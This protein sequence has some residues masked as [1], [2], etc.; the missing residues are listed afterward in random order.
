M[1][2][3]GIA[4]KLGNRYEAKIL[5]LKL[6]DVLTGKADWLRFE[7]IL[8]D[9]EGFE[10]SLGIGEKTEWYQTKTNS[11]HGNWTTSALKAAGVLDAFTKRL[12]E[13]QASTCHFVSQ[14][15]SQELQIFS[16]KTRIANDFEEFLASLSENKTLEFTNVAG[17][18]ETTTENCFSRLK[19]S[20]FE[21]ISDRL[22]ENNASTL[23]KLLFS[24]WNDNIFA[25]LRDYLE[26]NINKIITTD[27][28]RDFLAQKNVGFKDWTLDPT[29]QKKISDQT[30]RYLSTYIPFGAGGIEIKRNEVQ[31]LSDEI[32]KERG[33]R[34][35]LLTGSAG[36]GKSGVIRALIQDLQDQSI[37]HLAY[38]VDQYLDCKTPEQIGFE[39]TGRNE[40]PAVTLHGISQ[41]NKSVLIIDQI[42]A[43]SEVSGRNGAVKNAILEFL[44]EIRSLNVTLVFVCR[45][46]DLD[47]DSRLK[48]LDN[49]QRSK[50]IKLSLLR[51][52]EEIKPTLEQKNIDVSNFSESQK[53]LLS[54]PLNL[55]IFLEAGTENYS[56]ANRDDLFK[57]LL[58]KK[59]K[60]LKTEKNISWDILEPLQTISNWMSEKQKLTAPSII[61]DEFSQSV[62]ILSSEG[63]I[64]QQGQNVNFFHESFFDYIYARSFFHSQKTVNEML[65]ST[66]Q[67]LFR[68]TQVRQILEVLRQY[69]RERYLEEL[70]GLFSEP[71][72]RY[73]IKIAIAKWLGSLKD[74]IQ[75][76]RN[77]AF[78]LH[79][80]AD[81]FSPMVRSILFGS[82]GWFDLHHK[83]DW[84]LPILNGDA[85][86]RRNFV[87]WW[88]LRNAH[89]R[90]KEVS[91][92][93]RV[94]WNHDSDRALELIQQSF[95]IETKGLGDRIEPIEDLIC[96]LIKSVPDG[97]FFKKTV[98]SRYFI[99]D[100]WVNKN[101]NRGSKV[102]KIYL[103]TWFSEHPGDHP[104]SRDHLSDIDIHSMSE[105]SKKNP[106]EFISGFIDALNR[107][108]DIINDIHSRGEYDSTFE[109]IQED[110]G[111]GGGKFAILFKNAIKTL[112]KEN[113]NLTKD[114][115]NSL[116][117]EKHKIFL[118]IYLE[119]VSENPEPL[120]STFLKV[121]A[122]DQLLKAGYDGIEWKSFASATKAVFPFL[123]E[124]QKLVIEKIILA[125]R[126]ELDRAI[127][128]A[129]DT[130]I[131][132]EQKRAWVKHDLNHSGY[133][134]W[135][136]LET[137]GEE[138]LTPDLRH[139]LKQLQRKFSG[140]KIAEARTIKGGWVKSPISQEHAQRMSD[141]QWLKAIKK[142]RDDK[143]REYHRN[144]V[145]GGAEQL[146]QLLSESTKKDPDRFARLLMQIPS[147]SNIAYSK[148]I[149]SGLHQAEGCIIENVINALDYAKKYPHDPFGYEYAYIVRSYP[150]VCEINPDIINNLL[151]YARTGEASD[152]KV[153]TT[154]RNNEKEEITS[155]D[156]IV[157][158]DDLFL[159]GMNSLRGASVLALASVFWKYPQHYEMV[160]NFINERTQSEPL[161][162][163][164]TVLIDLLSPFYNYDREK[165]GF[166]LQR[167]VQESLDKEKALR[168]LTS[169]HG[170]RL[171]QH[172]LY[173]ATAS[174]RA[175]VDLLL[176][177]EENNDRMIGAWLVFGASYEISEFSDLSE[178]LVQESIEHLRLASEVASSGYAYVHF[179]EITQNK[180]KMYF[181]HEDE[182][183]RR[184]AT[185]VF[186][187][188]R[189]TE[190]AENKELIDSYLKSKAFKEDD[191]S[192]FLRLLKESSSDVHEYVIEAAEKIISKSKEPIDSRQNRHRDYMY[193]DDLLEREY[194]ASEDSPD[195]RDRYLDIIDDMLKLEIYG[196][197]KIVKSHERHY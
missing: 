17:K 167:L 111:Y 160:E 66:Q 196:S 67:H 46:F 151:D 20:Y 82:A 137:I 32:N 154:S 76:E 155:I 10:F 77:I 18:W 147:N 148:N 26:Q 70:A 175:L 74:P 28:V 61:L 42:D 179:K 88:I 131:Q 21:T 110:E 117:P 149:L 166:Y 11:S 103:E 23:A 36:Y 2:S 53:R 64:V 75:Q 177:S 129:Q 81:D 38:R 9:F 178:K 89:E 173:G 122:S 14:H 144:Y 69:N 170:I 85:E 135:S 128:V 162:S 39:L 100:T 157:R 55:V 174:G 83:A 119:A 181:E 190:I 159:S 158:H 171:M 45:D 185:E 29:L 47:N 121:L 49:S 136:I 71:K 156:D 68:R 35:I 188:I 183:V 16:E 115:L 186:Q 114:Y 120:L 87:L 101:A 79:E 106:S 99:L 164:R 63:L 57:A 116:D 140:K 163:V 193:L 73:H 108:V 184:N 126:P 98:Q 90:P 143:D 56:F 96:D 168:P 72:I 84:L 153:R 51:W 92:L 8:S 124:H 54:L 134:Q 7:G 139:L 118:H 141:Q 31:E 65:L 12:V 194:A 22:A 15:P 192:D 13:S 133:E 5:V 105:F 161:A 41:G 102:L 197:E 33:A 40:S 58:D 150:E 189:Q 91:E 191:S 94:W 112:A 113:A 27:F 60:V 195:L 107:A 3:G 52:E 1:Y 138:N 109:S 50:R 176:N 30:K 104:F 80:N 48:S 169:Y 125:H 62:E 19:C 182:H 187:H 180:L 25:I 132:I 95:L 78:S 6:F 37:T 34:V 93:L 130:S 165:C 24:N 142:Y 152:D 4:D 123:T 86:K 97:M 172:V 146:A 59:G 44:D 127:E 145:I 43:V